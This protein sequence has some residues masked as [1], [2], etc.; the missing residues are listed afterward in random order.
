MDGSADTFI[1]VSQCLWACRYS[2]SVRESSA[3]KWDSSRAYFPAAFPKGIFLNLRLSLKRMREREDVVSIESGMK[4]FKWTI[5]LKASGIPVG[6]N[7]CS[8][9][10]AS[11]SR[12]ASPR[13]SQFTPGFGIAGIAGFWAGWHCTLARAL[14]QTRSGDEGDAGG[15]QGTAATRF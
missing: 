12:N 5:I 2:A 6:F 11:A 8:F 3:G 9:F 1:R 15:M 13:A 4:S 14:A 7:S 10:L